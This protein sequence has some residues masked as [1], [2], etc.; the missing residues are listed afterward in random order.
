MNDRCRIDDREWQGIGQTREDIPF[1][2]G[3]KITLKMKLNKLKHLHRTYKAGLQVTSYRSWFNIFHL[4]REQT[5][6][7]RGQM[8]LG[9]EEQSP[10]HL[11]GLNLNGK[12]WGRDGKERIC[13]LRPSAKGK[14]WYNKNLCLHNPT[15]PDPGVLTNIHS[16]IPAHSCE[17]GR[18]CSVISPSEW[19][20]K[21]Q[22]LQSLH[23][24]TCLAS[25]GRVSPWPC[26]RVN[27]LDTFL[28]QI[29]YTINN[30]LF[31]I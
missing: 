20:T 5:E 15:S 4:T 9:V 17:T 21:T 12:L 26:S 30:F 14:E 3:L 13:W 28:V 19:K 25:Q 16:F 31:F 29:V 8:Y 24:Q 18:W 11:Q 7:Q 2:K 10:V 1:L 23:Q 27:R 6:T 22:L